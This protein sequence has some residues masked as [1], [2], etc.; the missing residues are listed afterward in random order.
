MGEFARQVKNGTI[1]GPHMRKFKREDWEAMARREDTDFDDK[2]LARAGIF[3][4]DRLTCLRSEMR[5]SHLPL[6]PNAIIRLAVGLATWRYCRLSAEAQGKLPAPKPGGTPVLMQ[7]SLEE[8]QISLATGQ[9]FA[10]DELIDGLGNELKYML[11]D[12][13]SLPT[14]QTLRTEYDASRKDIDDISHEF[15]I[16]MMYS[17]SVEYWLD[18]VGLGYGLT[19]Q[20]TS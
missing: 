19:H 11:D 8:L 20:T 18:C 15:N 2:R 6:Q 17:C 10:P 13:Q 1:H 16:A 5:L 4:D 3:F 9:L 12:L 14:N 7:S